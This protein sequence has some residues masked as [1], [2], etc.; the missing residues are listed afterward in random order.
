MKNS[1]KILLTFALC[2]GLT[3]VVTAQERTKK[4][5]KK[6]NKAIS[7]IWK[8]RVVEETPMTTD[9]DIEFS[10]F[11]EES[12]LSAISEKGEELG[13]LLLRRGYGCKIGG[14]GTGSYADGETCSADGGTYETFDYVVFFDTDLKILKSIVVDYPGD[15]GYEICSKN[16]LKQFNGYTGEELQYGGDI[17]AIS[18]ATISG[19]S[20]TSDIQNV[21]LYLGRLLAD[22][23][24]QALLRTARN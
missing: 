16:W 6:I 4:I 21:Y 12:K 22:D 23:E 19:N 7:Q 9:K 5:D 20:F 14:C 11:F 1:F 3:L 10:L 17:D 24:S 13:Y 8:N 15:Y 2:L 18:G